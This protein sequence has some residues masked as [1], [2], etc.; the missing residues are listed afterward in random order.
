MPILT[1]PLQ[2]A[3]LRK[4]PLSVLDQLDVTIRTSIKGIIGLPGSH[5]TNMIYAP[6]KFRG[7]GVVKCRWEAFLQHFAIATKL[8]NLQD[9]LF[10]AVYDCQ[11]ELQICKEALGVSHSTAKANRE[12]LREKAYI[13]WSKMSIA[14]VGIMKFKEYPQANRFMY[15][16]TSL[17]SSEWTTAIK[18]SVG[19]ANVKGDGYHVQKDEYGQIIRGQESNRCRRCAIGALRQRDRNHPTCAWFLPLW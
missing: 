18:L 10:H 12:E 17:S 13:E 11:A 6:R 5:A 19:Y 1:Y 7:L 4:I 2:S 8:S 16:R 3:P 14:G 15:G 9:A